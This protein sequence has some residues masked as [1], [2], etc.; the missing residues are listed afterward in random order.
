[1]NNNEIF[2]YIIRNYWCLLDNEETEY[3]LLKNKYQKKTNNLEL[4]ERDI[5]FQKKLVL[6]ILSLNKIIMNYCPICGT[7]ARTISAKTAKCGH[8]W[9]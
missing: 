9:F 2:D 8:T 6:R 4:T 7:L 3:I 1:M 5:E